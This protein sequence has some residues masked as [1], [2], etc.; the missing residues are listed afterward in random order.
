MT[1][2]LFACLAPSI[3]STGAVY[4]PRARTPVT[5][6]VEYR[7]A[8]TDGSLL[9]VQRFLMQVNTDCIALTGCNFFTI[10]RSFMLTV[11]NPS[12]IYPKF[13]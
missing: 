6:S 13:R 5:P 7:P 3:Y 1:E 4:T 9:Q 11:R 10:D 2:A 12:I 8:A